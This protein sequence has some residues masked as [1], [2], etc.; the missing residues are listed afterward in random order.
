M[1]LGSFEESVLLAISALGPNARSPACK[2]RIEAASGKPVS[3]GAFWMTVARMR[4]KGLIAVEVS[5]PTPV[6]GGRSC[7]LLSLTAVGMAA[8]EEAEAFRRALRRRG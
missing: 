5:E 3:V 6:R 4:E 8:L 2:E 1:I 7:G